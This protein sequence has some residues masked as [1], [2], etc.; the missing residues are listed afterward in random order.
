MSK[1]GMSRRGFL[2]GAAL[3]GAGV[4]M[5]GAAVGCSPKAAES[6]AANA[7]TVSGGGASPAHRW[8]SEAAAAWRTPIDPIADDQIADGGTFDVVVVGGGQSGTWC[9]RSASMNGASVAVL[10]TQSEA[11]FLYVGGEVGTVN[12]QWA[13]EHGATEIDKEDFMNELFRR[14]AGRS[15]QR[16][17][18]DYVYHS[19]E[20]LDWALE[21]LDD[22][23]WLNDP[24]NVHVFSADHSENMV[25]DPS[26]YK[27]Y[28]G[29]VNFRPAAE[30]GA[31]TWNWGEK[32]MK[33]HRDK[34]IEDGT[35]WNWAYR[36][37]YLEKDDSGRIAAVIAQKLDDET[38]HRFTA[39]KGVVLA[40][41]DFSAD[42]DMLRDI[43]DEYRHLAE[44]Y[45]NIEAA[46]AGSMF[47]VRNGD[48]LKMGVWAGGHVEVGP[49]AGMNTG[50]VGTGAPW[51]PG[52]VILNQSGRRFCDECAGG[53]EGA[54]YMIPRQPRGYVVSIADANWREVVEKMPPCHGGI[55]QTNGVSYNSLESNAAKIDAAQPSS[56]ADENGLF[57]A[58]TLE[59]LLDAI[60]I[61][62]DDQKATALAELERFNGF[63]ANGKDEDF[64]MDPRILKALDTP[65]FYA[66][67]AAS[68]AISMGLC[69][70]AGLDISSEH[71]VLDEMLAPMPGLYSIGNNSGNR[72]IVN[73]ATPLS[74]MSLGFC[75]TEGMTLG[76]KLAEA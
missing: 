35:Q 13:L 37:L 40:A 38:Y 30:T 47:G 74:G 19:G 64:A 60:G 15:N 24:A 54:G 58:N 44:S 26:G 56:E 42:E 28:L 49:R 41:G 48:G 5:A 66:T 34:A 16:L 31:P 68:D 75:L 22:P 1:E 2:R 57:C 63:A 67:V 43:N 50:Q 71:E 7:E 4:L 23:D 8:Q 21:D 51:G 17:I 29:T 65:P 39:N 61:Y 14:N 33:H 11:D 9:A 10:E 46:A 76:K 55:D 27:Y 25:M 70:T 20:Y 3:T 53:A 72:Y 18:R 6:G 12:C 45:G 69:Q 32:V 52:F 59:E 36:A 62:N 73:Y